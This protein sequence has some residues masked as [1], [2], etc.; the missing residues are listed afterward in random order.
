M[1]PQT[2]PVQTLETGM[3]QVWLGVHSSNEPEQVQLPGVPQLF[4]TEIPHCVPQVVA[5][6]SALQ[7]HF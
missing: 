4:V 6:G 2:R 1:E 3:Q 5:T 7:M